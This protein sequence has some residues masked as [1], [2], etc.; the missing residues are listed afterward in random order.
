MRSHFLNLFISLHFLYGCETWLLTLG[1]DY[2]L[3]VFENRVL[4]GIFG[5]KRVKV[6]REWTKIQM[7]RL[8]ICT[9]VIKSRRMGWV[10]HVAHMGG[11]GVYRV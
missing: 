10:G 6:T 8:M 11:G 3:R 5:P 4:T 1:E 7:R 9:R 2:R